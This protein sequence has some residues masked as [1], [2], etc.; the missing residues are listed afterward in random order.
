MPAVFSRKDEDPM[1]AIRRFKRLCDKSQLLTDIKKNLRHT[2]SS[3]LNAARKAA[4]RKRH[5]KKLAK[6]APTPAR[7]KKRNKSKRRYA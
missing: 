6:E 5:L 1:N 2:K 4:A 7:A 3:I